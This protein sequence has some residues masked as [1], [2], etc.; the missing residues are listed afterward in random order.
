MSNTATVN[1]T[2]TPVDDAVVAMDD[3]YT[4]TEDTAL[5]VTAPGVLG[6][7]S[8]IDMDPLSAFV[9]TLPSNGTLTLNPN[10]SFTYTPNSDF[11]G[12]D[13]FSYTVSD[14]V[15]TSNALVTINV[16]ADNDAPINSVPVAT[17]TTAEDTSLVLSGANKISVSDVDVGAGNLTVTLTVA[18]GTA[19]LSGTAGLVS[20]SGNGTASVTLTGTPAT[21]NAALDNLTF[22]P[23]AAYNGSASITVTTNDN[24]NSP[25]PAK[26]DT[27][28]ININ[29]TDVNDPPVAVADTFNVF[30][31]SVA[32]NLVVT[33]ND[34][35]SDGTIVSVTPGAA[36]NG[37]VS[38]SGLNVVY[39]PNAN[40]FGTDSFS[41]TVTD[42][43]G[44]TATAVVTVNV[45][46]LN[47]AP[48]A[49][50]DSATL[51]EDAP[52]TTINVLA[53]DNAGPLEGGQTLSIIGFG[54]VS[55]VLAGSFTFTPTTITFTP[56]ANFSGTATLEYII[57]DN[58]QDSDLAG[59]LTNNFKQDTGL[60]TITVNPDSDA[61]T[62]TVAPATGNEDTAIALSISAVKTDP[63]ET[64]SDVSITG[65]P[66]G[67]TLSAGT[68]NG[69]GSWTVPVAS[70]AGLSIT[71]ASNFHGTFTLGVSVSSTDSPDGPATTTGSILVTVTAFNDAPLNTVP[72]AQTTAEETNLVFSVAGTNAITVSD[73][74]AAEGTGN[75]TTTLSVNDGILTLAGTAS[76][77]V[78][79]DGTATVVVTGT[80]AAINAALDGLIYTP[81]LN[82]N[83][84]DL[85]TVMTD[86]LGNSPGPNATHT[87]TVAITVTPVAD[88]PV[89][90]GDSY[91]VNE[92]ATLSVASPGVL[93][94]DTDGD[95]DPLT[96][97]G[98][99][100]PL[101]ITTAQGGTVS[102]N[103]NGSFTYT[104]PANYAGPDNFS[105]SATDGGLTSTSAMVSLTVD[106]VN[107]AP[108]APSVSIGAV[109]NTAVNF[110]L[111]TIA[112]D[113]ET[114][115]GSLV[116]TPT[117]PAPAN[118]SLTLSPTTGVWQYTPNPGFTGIDTI[119][120]SV[121]DGG[122]GASL[123]LTSSGV[124][125]I[126]V[127]P[128]NDP[129]VNTV[130]GPQ[131][132]NEDTTLTFTASIADPDIGAGDFEVT[133]SVGNG[134]LTLANTSG[135]MFSAGGDGTATMTFTGNAT[136]VNAAMLSM[137]YT[138]N[139][140]F[141]GSD[142]FTI[143]TND[144]G[145]T[146]A[147]GAQSDTD[148]FAITV[149]P[150]AD[151]PIASD[152]IY[153]A[154]GL[155]T[156]SAPG[157]LNN[158]DG[159]LMETVDDSDADGNTFTVYSVEGVP[160]NVGVATT[161]LSGATVTLNANGSFTYDPATSASF[162]ALAAGQTDTDSFSYT[163][164][165]STMF[166]SALAIVTIN[167]TGVNDAPLAVGDSATVA[168]D[169]A[170]T[171]AVLTNDS[172]PDAASTPGNGSIINPTTVSITSPPSN[173]SVVVNPSGSVTYTPNS[174]Y[175][176]PDSF[177]YTVKDDAGLE[178]AP[179]VVSI[180]VTPVNDAPVGVADTY[181]ATEDTPLTI[182]APG[183]LA[184]DTDVDGN[185]LTTVL[186][187][188]TNG[189]VLLNANG[190][191]TFTPAANFA[192]VAT[193][194]YRA[195]DGLL[196]SAP[197]VVTIN[198]AG[199]N[200]APVAV[201]DTVAVTEDT[202]LTFSVIGNDTDIDGTIDPTTVVIG[203]GPTH[204]SLS[205]NPTTGAVTYTPA[206]DYFGSDSF[207]YT[208][209]DNGSPVATSNI[210]TVTLNISGTPDAPVAVA[211]AYSVSEDS[212]LNI[213]PTGVLSN[214]SDVDGD[215]LSSVL[216][217]A[218]PSGLTF[219]SNGSFT[220]L[221]P[222][223]Y[224]SLAAGETATVTFQYKAND[225]GLDSNV[226]NV[227]I[228]INGANDAPVATPA[229]PFTMLEDT[230]LSGTVT[231]SDIDT[232][233]TL[234][235]AATQNPA[236]GTLVLNGD[237]TFTYTPNIG[238]NG[239][240]L[241]K[242]KVTDNDG[243]DSAFE[244]VLINITPVNS[245]PTFNIVNVNVNEDSGAF[246]SSIVSSVTPGPVDEA[247][248][249]VTFSM[250]STSGTPGLFS[251][252]PAISAAGV[253][254]FTPAANQSGTATFDVT[255]TD[256][257][258]P[259]KSTTKSF[260]ITVAAVEDPTTASPLNLGTIG[261]DTPV[262]FTEAQLIAQGSDP[263]ST[264]TLTSVSLT[265]G[266]GT[267]SGPVSGVYTF[268][269]S[270]ESTGAVVVGFTVT[271]SNAA[272]STVNFTYI[273]VNDAPVLTLPMSGLPTGTEGD[274]L[275]INGVSVADI[276]VGL[277]NHQL[278]ITSAAGTVGLAVVP[279]TVTVTSIAGGIRIVGTPANI[280][281]A[282]LAS[283][284]QFTVGDVDP[285]A[286]P[287]AAAVIN[288][289]LNDLGNTPSPA[290]TATGSLSLTVTDKAPALALTDGTSPVGE[291][292]EATSYSLTIGGY[293]DWA[294]DPITSLQIRWGD[295][296]PN[297]V[298]TGGA[299]TALNSSGGSIVVSHFYADD[300][301]G[302]NNGVNLQ[303]DVVTQGNALQ[304][305]GIGS[306]SP[307][308]SPNLIVNNVDPTVSS[309]FAPSPL[310]QGQNGSF[311]VTA[312]DVAGAN[313]PLTYSYDW[314]NNGTFDLVTSSS[315]VTIP[316]SFITTAGPNAQQIRYRVE[317]GDGGFFESI[318]NEDVL[319]VIFF[320]VDDQTVDEDAGIITIT[321]KPSIDIPAGVS[322]PVTVAYSD[323]GATL[324]SD[325]APSGSQTVTFIPGDLAGVGRTVQ[326]Q[327]ID[328]FIPEG[329]EAVGITLS[330]SYVPGIGQPVVDVSDTALVGI[331]DDDDA[332]QVTEVK[333]NSVAGPGVAVGWQQPFLDA[334]D[335]ETVGSGLGKGYSIP[336]G[337]SAQ[338]KALPWKGINQLRVSFTDDVD[339][340]TVVMNSNVKLH[341]FS[342]AGPA[343][344]VPISS[345]TAA[346]NVM[347]VNLSAPLSTAN[348]RLE[349][350]DSVKSTG[351]VA[352]DG[353]FT[354]N[355]SPLNS[356]GVQPVGNPLNNFNFQFVVNPGNTNQDGG[357][358][359][360]D[361][362]PIFTVLSTYGP[363]SAGDIGYSYL[364]DTDGNGGINIS[365][366]TII[367]TNF[368]AAP[369]ATFPG[370]AASSG[371][372][373]VIT[374]TGLS[375]T[376]PVS[377]APTP[378]GALGTTSAAPAASSE[379]N[380]N[381][382]EMG[383]LLDEVLN[384]L[385][386]DLIDD[387]IG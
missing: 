73:A 332:F 119:G 258:S 232:S 78:A 221:T 15:G 97:A 185:P 324:G 279:G 136:D 5:V 145:N 238:E 39:T 99:S 204:G 257:G 45:R 104:P 32:N 255:A 4:T 27:D 254:T 21:V 287:T 357:V 17:L 30:E 261:E 68:N 80:P 292:D 31:D 323:F 88:T 340:S 321:V 314:D 135:L 124:L 368:L 121:T 259:V 44:A 84:G 126:V 230:V 348:F 373:S 54:A 269:P 300:P 264:I 341:I 330:T 382:D 354:N 198:V 58:G 164:I 12:S 60:L 201:N 51:N 59:V 327:I 351:G 325:Y 336:T 129:P 268:T 319:P 1:I 111:K 9:N 193:F 24:G 179:A 356:G 50:D 75:V 374:S 212:T 152:D 328:N 175:N 106:P 18:N 8:N 236:K 57:R 271:G 102:L 26:S 370:N 158:I 40:Y 386:S 251:V 366:A 115:V 226:V 272:S 233:N 167:R 224:Q 248:Q 237:G 355:S 289:L 378:T 361:A 245:V 37:T 130:P 29:V 176:G 161:L 165:D 312:S 71:P 154:S 306:F 13:S 107:D 171:I 72:G 138:P 208:V 286:A 41:Y 195:N 96:V 163:I 200:D 86:D 48:V 180:T 307:A 267:L 172:D 187:G 223:S 234:T 244:T 143:V 250:V 381:T 199:V 156:I 334:A 241:F 49:F 91:T 263:D 239:T 291:I 120:Y 294:T 77:T 290:M 220:Y 87:A 203:T 318:R 155:L 284:L 304:F 183:V 134:I 215:V 109:E 353:D 128:F 70:L 122:Q 22:A 151:A 153:S 296:T 256:N 194:T 213:V 85:L 270:P 216:V 253:L 281:A 89:A 309:A 82:Y 182:A 174:N 142:T 2:V 105:Y 350:Q 35:D 170:V 146:G 298:L 114:P 95:M 343:T 139:L 339:L 333:V 347:I 23:T 210:A 260:T 346:G 206:A 61:P 310:V 360:S 262:T 371:A 363:V 98:V 252:A 43:D 63:S 249:T 184:N 52:A 316:A 55:G 380:D 222:A 178:S 116:F 362:T 33:F 246:S 67:A 345:I 288:F 159:S 315:T 219:N 150:V 192:G 38:V 240:D 297:T 308:R 14:G 112:S 282:L 295:G 62:L 149:T 92:D 337:S 276:D 144:Q 36:T 19:T 131:T 123:P 177:S 293:A 358:N 364:L 53:G 331:T 189:T 118:G 375:I 69:G 305:N 76:L 205:V 20:H 372:V 275:G 352:L 168:E 141:N 379:G 209:K 191:F 93:G 197:T 34:T 90:N 117:G 273:A 277:G 335:L 207:T 384:D 359:I 83:G 365:D 235:F 299:I 274:V 243:A 125:T 16:N 108:L 387:L 25:G 229:G 127:A 217:G 148:S 342:D 301:A 10:G 313:D 349:V 3:T 225:G 47:D 265:S 110:D 302:V 196:L 46:Q 133:L 278:D 329:V 65:V 42:N 103:A 101:S 140:D 160:A 338:T 64:L 169:G 147:P 100:F 227:V 202:P 7:D 113:L 66:T 266:S 94:N 81:N 320:T 317:D 157:V 186:V 344:T 311:H 190:G 231:G 303:V 376:T 28:P 6:N 181:A 214:D 137:T 283:N 162:K 218:A 377:L 188:S 242:F 369:P 166:V 132:I 211:D 280:N 173:G 247:G 322:I 79:G 383:T 74:D 326:L 228:T 367:F 56:P 285:G 385:T 11:N